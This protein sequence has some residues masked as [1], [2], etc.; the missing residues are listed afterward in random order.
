MERK[1]SLYQRS[2]EDGA[3]LVL[4]GRTHLQSGRHIPIGE[5]HE[6]LVAETR[7]LGDEFADEKGPL[8]EHIQERGAARQ[9]V[10]VTEQAETPRLLFDRE[11]TRSWEERHPRVRA[12]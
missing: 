5:L 9:P 6:P 1:V 11:A 4:I 8:L 7:L 3:V 2:L 12:V 10:R